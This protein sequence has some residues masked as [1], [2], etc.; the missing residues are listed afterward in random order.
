MPPSFFSLFS[1]VLTVPEEICRSR[2]HSYS[3]YGQRLDYSIHYII[4]YKHAFKM[5]ELPAYDQNLKYL[6]NFRCRSSIFVLHHL[7]VVQYHL[8]LVLCLIRWIVS[9]KSIKNR[10]SAAIFQDG[11]EWR[12]KHM[13]F[14]LW[15]VVYYSGH[16]ILCIC[17]VFC[18]S[19]IF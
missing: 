9:E 15:L 7:C 16:Q 2:H 10:F 14:F 6:P 13:L 17:H 12:L 3:T 5:A 18:L 8:C 1:H 4:L 19:E 11:G